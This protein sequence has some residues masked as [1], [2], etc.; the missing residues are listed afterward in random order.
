RLDYKVTGLEAH[1]VIPEAH[2]FAAPTRVDAAD[3]DSDQAV[4]PADGLTGT[5]LVL[6][7]TMI[8]AMDAAD[9][10]TELGASDVKIASNVLEA[11]NQIEKN[12]FSV[13]VLD[14]NLGSEQS[15]PVAIRLA[16]LGVPFILS[17]GYGERD[18]IRANYPPCPI[19]RKP[20]SSETMAEAVFEAIRSNR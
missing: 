5:A 8:I 13:A 1:F 4:R 18:D 7:D 9:I 20:F 16:E 19:L 3:A 17:T 6:E 15:L 10:L 2:V 14:V 11:L 12:A